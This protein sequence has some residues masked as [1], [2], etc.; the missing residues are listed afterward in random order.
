MRKSSLLYTAFG[1]M[2]ALGTL[3]FIADA[4]YFY[5]TFWWYDIMMHFLAGFTGGL[6]ILWFIRPFGILKSIYF[7]LLGILVIGITWEI[8]EYVYHIAQTT[9]YWQ[10]T[11]LDLIADVAGAVLACLYVSGRR[12]KS[13]LESPDI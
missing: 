2:I 3:H 11:I 7:A 10:D 4:F 13:S 8:F 5:W 6:L 1:F 12:P 9:D